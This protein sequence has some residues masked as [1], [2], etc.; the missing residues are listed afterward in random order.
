MT[1]L[2]RS[3]LRAVMWRWLLVLA[4]GTFLVVAAQFI[5]EAGE[6]ITYLG[7]HPGTFLL[8]FLSRLP[9]FLLSFLPVS[10]L[11]AGMLTVAPMLREGTL[12]ALA[13]AGI[14]PA[15]VLRT[16]LVV[17][18]ASG[19]LAT[20]LA[21]QVVP[22]MMRVTDRLIAVMKDRDPNHLTRSAGWRSGTTHWSSAQALPSAIVYH[23]LAI[24]RTDADRRALADELTWNGRAW[25]LLGVDAIDG[26]RQSR[27]ERTSPEALGFTA[28][29][30]PEE[31]AQR[32]RPDSARTSD[33]LFATGTPRRWHLLFDRLVSCLLPIL[34][35][36]FALPRF[37]RW[38]DRLR[39]AI[40]AFRSL[41][42]TIPPLAGAA[43]LSRLLMSSGSSTLWFA[44]GTIAALGLIA[45][46]RWRT[47]RL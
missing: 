15:R 34:C 33:E 29:P 16:T 14:A 45:W 39:P 35:L 43:V 3:I 46:R 32:L 8:Y 5:G 31:L 28:P 24:F 23:R 42:W 40:A 47:M 41:A 12:M 18:I 25:E 4:M 13:A 30:P 38:E 1:T 22:R 21:D 9:E 27:L 11:A 7:Q 44:L 6:N 36:A 10:A 37:I 2:D 20:I 17:A 19:M 26:Q